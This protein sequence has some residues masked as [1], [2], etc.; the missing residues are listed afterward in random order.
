[1]IQPL[2]DNPYERDQT[3]PLVDSKKEDLDVGR[4]A[5]IATY[6]THS[7]APPNQVA[8]A[9]LMELQ[10]P[11]TLPVKIGNTLFLAHESKEPKHY[12]FRA[13]NADTAEN[14]ANNSEEFIRRMDQEGAIELATQFSDP[15]LLSM[16]KAVALRM[17]KQGDGPAGYRV[18]QSKDGQYL[19]AIT[20]KEDGNVGGS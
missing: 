12:I 15:R 17:S 10:Q 9:I 1:M 16:I 5:V 20:L 3:P 18:Y 19:V 4:I 2:Q 6:H 13:L 7:E 11:G 14:Y 8:M